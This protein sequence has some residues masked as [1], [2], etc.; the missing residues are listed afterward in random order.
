MCLGNHGMSE[1]QIFPKEYNLSYIKYIN[2]RWNK[3]IYLL[4]YVQYGMIIG[5]IFC[6]ISIMSIAT[7]M[8]SSNDICGDNDWTEWNN[9]NDNI[10]VDN[11]DEP[12]WT[13]YLSPVIGV[14]L[15]LSACFIAQIKSK[16][17]CTDF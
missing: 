8:A 11:L 4:L 3:K 12:L 16:P 2:D 17:H 1:L 5:G 7:M 15:W 14:F 13:M 9:N 10:Y 6:M